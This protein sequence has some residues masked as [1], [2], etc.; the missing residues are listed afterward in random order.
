ML[1]D[2]LLLTSL[3]VGTG[4]DT[5]AGAGAG[6]GAAT[7]GVVFWFPFFILKHFEHSPSL[8]GLPKNPQPAKQREGIEAFEEEE[9]DIA[10]SVDGNE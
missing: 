4:T 2:S 7:I 5:G 6:A 3:C 9:E 10:R 8:A 1:I